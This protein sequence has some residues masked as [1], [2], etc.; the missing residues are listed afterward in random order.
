[1]DVL[2]CP[3][4]EVYKKERCNER[5]RHHT[6]VSSSFRGV[7]T[8]SKLSFHRTLRPHEMQVLRFHRNSTQGRSLKKS[9]VCKCVRIMAY[10]SAWSPSTSYAATEHST[11]PQLQSTARAATEHNAHHTHL[12]AVAQ[13]RLRHFSLLPSSPRHAGRLK[14]CYRACL[15]TSVHKNCDW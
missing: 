15:Q 9:F 5:A 14:H 7:E 4:S 1:M 6:G 10:V 11:R 3:Q 13:E 2:M 12:A 8:I